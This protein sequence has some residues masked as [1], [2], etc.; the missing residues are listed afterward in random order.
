MYVL[1]FQIQNILHYFLWN[2]LETPLAYWLR[3]RI[4]LEKP[5]KFHHLN[6]MAQLEFKIRL[7]STKKYKNKNRA[8]IR[9]LPDLKKFILPEMFP[10]FYFLD[11]MICRWVN[12]KKRFQK[13]I[14]FSLVKLHICFFIYI[15]KYTKI[16]FL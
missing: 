15:I 5:I 4:K 7:K 11:Y 8:E 12:G 1:F 3:S 6:F 16:K 14:I 13:L 10:V 9:K 2:I